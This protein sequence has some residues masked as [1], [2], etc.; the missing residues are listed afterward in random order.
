VDGRLEAAG[1]ELAALEGQ[2]ARDYRI[3]FLRALLAADRALGEPP[4]LPAPEAPAPDWDH[5]PAA[6]PE[7]A[8]DLGPIGSAVVSEPL[9]EEY[10]RD[11]PAA[12]A[13]LLLSQ[14][15]WAESVA[16]LA[17]VRKE[18]PLPLYARAWRRAAY[19]AR[20][21][22]DVLGS[23]DAEGSRERIGSLLGTALEAGTEPEKLL[24]ATGPDR[25]A[26]ALILAAAARRAVEEGRDPTRLCEEGEALLPESERELRGIFRAARLRRLAL[27]GIHE[28]A[29]YQEAMELIG[30]T[31][32]SWMGRLAAVELRVGLGARRRRPALEEALARADALL[33]AAP[34][35]TAPRVLRGASRLALGQLEDAWVE[36]A[37]PA[38]G[39]RREVFARV[40]AARLWLRMGRERRLPEHAGRARGFAL[41]VLSVSP[42]HPE[43]LA[44]AGAAEVALAEAAAGRGEDETELLAG[45][46]DHLA[47][48]IRSVPGCAAARYARAE[49][50]FLRGEAARR[51]GRESAEDYRAAREDLDAA[52]KAEPGM[53]AARMLLG[54]VEFARGRPAEATAAWKGLLADD[55]AWDSEELR[56]WI[57]QA[58]AGGP[59]K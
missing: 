50:S 53:G 8:R 38:G 29:R 39:P 56:G 9:M 55:P 30:E 2:E 21:Y 28:E 35:W 20:R 41:E 4:P 51:G 32:A 49:A 52:L 12:K 3:A 1:R 57:K 7:V 16:A 26:R 59:R 18:Q 24:P 25:G 48:S 22:A 5:A 40:L 14:G 6:W 10:R 37:G 44:L 17:E 15:R 31:P 13:L 45:A 19:L 33:A 34:D 47:A 54:I 58:A 27:S 23:P 11:L 42:D 36:L 46:L 43:A